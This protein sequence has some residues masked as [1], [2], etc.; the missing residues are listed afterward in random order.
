MTL[1]DYDP[2]YA[3]QI[4]DIYHTTIHTINIADY[5]DAQVHAWAPLP[6]DYAAWR[7]RLARK[8]PLLA[9]DGDAV[10]GF[11][12]L[13]DGG[14]IDCFYVHKDHQRRGVPLTIRSC[15]LKGSSGCMPR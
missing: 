11:A 2:R 1:I 8:R 15:F 14:H 5:D 6:V 12:E 13:E 9:M 10:V 3:E 7:E 4:A